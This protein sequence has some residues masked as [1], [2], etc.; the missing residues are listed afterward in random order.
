MPFNL[1]VESGKGIVQVV[2]NGVVRGLVCDSITDAAL[3]D[4]CVEAGYPEGLEKHL[5][6]GSELNK[7]ASE[8]INFLGCKQVCNRSNSHSLYCYNHKDCNYTA[9]KCHGSELY[10]TVVTR[11]TL[12]STPTTPTTSKNSDHSVGVFILL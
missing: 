2:Q 5:R 8:Y 1:R 4:V 3:N 9:I 12:E 6:K 11:T 10:T 7:S